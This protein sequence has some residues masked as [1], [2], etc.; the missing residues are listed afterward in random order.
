MGFK[1]LLAGNVSLD[2]EEFFE[3]ARSVFDFIIMQFPTFWN[4]TI[5]SIDKVPI[6]IGN[7][8]FGFVFVIVGYL[9]IRVFVY[10][11]DK[12][13]LSHFDIDIPHRYTI[14]LFLSYFLFSILFLLTLYF[15]KVPLTVFTFIGGAL[16]LGIGFGAKN[17]MNNL[18]CGVVIVTEHPIRVGDLIEVDNLL[19]VVENI[20]FRATVVKSLENTHILIPNSIIL[21]SNV[22]NWTLSDKVIRS[23]VKL[24]VSYGSPI[25]KVKKILLKVAHDHKSVLTYNKHQSPIVFFENFGDSGLEFELYYWVA[26]TRPLDLKQVS[27]ELRFEINRLFTENGIK[28]PFPQTDIHVKEPVQVDWINKSNK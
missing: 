16:A 23:T 11:V 24:S 9:G 7:L 15:I 5:F 19:G 25:E 13:I 26:M 17:I 27:S 4:Y 20:G 28:I 1:I 3:K 6:T 2:K 22:L 12:R 21:E 10:Q 14:R 8:I 18:L